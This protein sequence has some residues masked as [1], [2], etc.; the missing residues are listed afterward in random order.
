MQD[1]LDSGVR[2]LFAELFRVDG[3]ALDDEDRRGELR[4]WDSL[5]HLTLV[6]ELEVRFGVTIDMELALE[7]ETFGDAK[8]IVAELRP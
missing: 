8:R 4:G 3:A 2:A 5:A 1:D 6:A 7:I